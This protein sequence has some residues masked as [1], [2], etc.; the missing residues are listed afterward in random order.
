M[1]KLPNLEIVHHNPLPVP[2]AHNRL[3]CPL[4]NLFLKIVERMLEQGE[5]VIKDGIVMFPGEQYI[6]PIELPQQAEE[7][8]VE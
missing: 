4:A 1:P 2:D 6:L 7:V 3:L 8:L 5:V